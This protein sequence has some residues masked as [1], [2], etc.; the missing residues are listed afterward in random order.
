MMELV[1]LKQSQIDQ[2]KRSRS[3]QYDHI[4]HDPRYSNGY[5]HHTQGHHRHPDKAGAARTDNTDKAVED[6]HLAF[7]GSSLGQQR[8]Q[9]QHNL[10][11]YSPISSPIP[12]ITAPEISTKRLERIRA[13]VQSFLNHRHSVHEHT[14]PRLFIVLPD[15]D[16]HCND[17]PGDD[18]SFTLPLGSG[19][20]HLH[21]AKHRGY[22]IDPGQE[23][24]FF[25]L[26]G[27]MVL[28]LLYFLKYGHENPG[29]AGEGGSSEASS[30]VC[31]E[32]QIPLQSSSQGSERQQQQQQQIGQG[33]KDTNLKRVQ[34]VSSLRRSDLPDAIAKDVDAKFD[35]MIEYLEGSRTAAVAGTISEA[36][37]YSGEQGT[38]GHKEHIPSGDDDDDSNEKEEALEGLTSLSD[39]HHLYSFL[40]LANLHNRIQS[41]QLGN[42]YRVSNTRGQVSWICLYHYRWTFLERNIDEFERWV[43]TR[44]GVFDKQ[45]GSVALTLFSRAQTRT[46]CSWIT[47]KVAPSLVEVHIKLG[48]KFGKK[49]LWRLAEAL[50]S[51]TVTVLSLDGCSHTE[52]SSC[53]ML[54]KKYNPILHL[55]TQGQLHS[56]ELSR[57]P[58][59]FARLSTKTVKATSLRRLEFGRGM[60]VSAKDRS[61]FSHF[62][63]SCSSLQELILPG[64]N[65]SGLQTQA[66]LMG[67]HTK[68][69]APSSLLTLDLSN[70]QLDDGAAIILAQGLYSTNICHLDLS[71]NERL[72]DMGAAR[73]IRAIGPRL[74]SLKMAQTGFGDLA[75]AALAKSMDGISFKKTLRDQL[76]LQQ[77]LDV[78]AIAAGYRPGLRITSDYPL[79]ANVIGGQPDRA[80]SSQPRAVPEKTYSMGHLVY[81][82]IEDNHCTVQ[83]FIALAKVKS[84]RHLVYLNL[85]GCKELQ[86]NECALILEKM[87]SPAMMTLRLARTGF[88]N[89]SAKSLARALLEHHQSPRSSRG[90]GGRGRAREP[91]QLEE[92]DLQGCAIGPEGLSAL[93]DAMVQVQASSCL[94][95]MDLGHCGYLNDQVVQKLLRVLVVPNGTTWIPAAAASKRY[96]RVDKGLYPLVASTT[97]GKMRQDTLEDEPAPG[98]QSS[99]ASLT[100]SDSDPTP[101]SSRVVLNGEDPSV[102]LSD[103]HHPDQVY[104]MPPRILLAPKKGFFTN[105]RQ[106]DLK[107]TR[108]GNGSAWLLAQALVQPWSMLESL[109]I[110]EPAVMTVQGMCWI[111]DSLC[112]NTTVQEFGIGKRD[113]PLQVDQDLFGTGILNLMELNKRIRSLTA[114]G[115]PLGSVAKGLLSNQSLH[116]VYLIRSRGQ[117]EDLQLMGQALA[118][119]RSLLVFWMGGSENSLL[120]PLQQ[121]QRHQEQQQHEN[122]YR[123]FH[124]I[125]TQ[126]NQPAPLQRQNC[127][128]HQPLLSRPRTRSLSK[129]ISSVLRTWQSKIGEA[130]SKQPSPSGDGTGP[131]AAQPLSSRA[132]QNTT[133]VGVNITNRRA[134]TSAT[135]TTSSGDAFGFWTQHPIIEGVRRNH[136]LIKVTLDSTTSLPIVT[137]GI[138]PTVGGKA[139]RFSRD[140]T[141]SA[142]AGAQEFSQQ[143]LRQFQMQQQQR[144]Q[145]KIQANRKLLKE[146][147]RVEWEELKSLGLDDD[148]IREVCG[149]AS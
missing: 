87:A 55:L 20:N 27:G 133:S 112:E 52:D 131:D 121:H 123:D 34:K 64:L 128:P 95:I 66:I 105:L 61:T 6:L 116:S 40:G 118:F 5:S 62:L 102:L 59:F 135:S 69:S 49:D 99:G 96:S 93:C 82:D 92:L 125:H 31:T 103:H 147:G 36:R 37:D 109:T 132:M 51:S 39:L 85:S 72:S 48:W 110:I 124:L 115:A 134:T 65:V 17:N 3:Q 119:T 141:W 47:N 2:S 12:A 32:A 78:V 81:L 53:K 100:R 1:D 46:F 104:Q 114:L 16:A 75:A 137:S 80:T 126:E 38:S 79:H 89:Q 41:G 98:R 111:M 21:I 120:G 60:E 33:F 83:G 29:A 15:D 58:S 76:Q 84:Q 28:T 113:I 4:L 70:S 43:V 67:I 63:N 127:H 22:E 130:R 122:I 45:S 74:A 73:V 142:M 54:H 139:G 42:L 56:L 57:F 145:K 10:G 136:S 86:D 144:L 90:N 129:N 140:S 107:S 23:E 8:Q 146:R 14:V 68:T 11:I 18:S 7:S 148:I 91:C 9:Q 117:F 71:K 77:R 149:D 143:E 35:K 44:R 13:S 24:D 50:A 106:L 26:Y 19:L 30:Q 101:R 108:M 94:K 88:S 138:Q 25:E 97:L